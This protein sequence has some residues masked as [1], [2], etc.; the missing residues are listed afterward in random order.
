RLSPR[1]SPPRVSRR[2]RF[3][4]CHTCLAAAKLS[5]ILKAEDSGVVAVAEF[6]VHRVLADE[7]NLP[8]LERVGNM[9]WQYPAHACHLITT[10]SARA[11]AAQDLRDVAGVGER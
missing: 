2:F 11:T 1:K 3:L 6:E 10:R 9:D 4:L 5:K 7:R 8:K